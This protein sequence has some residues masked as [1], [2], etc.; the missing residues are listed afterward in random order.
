MRIALDVMGGDHAP[1]ATLDGAVEALDLLDPGDE[2]V[3]VGAEGV[4]RDHLVSVGVDDGRIRVV[5]SSDDITMD[6]LPV[7]AV[8]AKPDSSIVRLARLASHRDEAPVDVIISAGNTG[9]CVSAA[10]MHLRRLPH[11]HRPG[12]AVTI[13]TFAGPVVVC[14]VGAN[15]QPRPT[16]LW[17]YGL[18]AESYARQVHG[19]EHPR[20]AVLNIGGE[21]AKGTGLIRETRNLF[22]STPGVDYVGYI[23]GRSLFE[24]EADVVV[25]DGFVGNVVLKLSEGLAKGLF[26]TILA[27]L[28][29]IDPDM[30]QAFAPIIRTIWSRHDY[31]ELGGAPLLGVNGT[32]VI[33]HGSS[34]ARTIRSAIRNSRSM[35]EHG[36]NRIIV[37]R[38]GELEALER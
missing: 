34:E 5:N 32:C 2:L 28:S 21:E 12:V 8:R 35:V 20:I 7:E 15:P 10:Q 36:L 22:R 26:Q 31:H 4:I 27:E 25:T 1:R 11:V 23:E 33:C 17:Q 14:D 29:S 24:G 6:D 13:P 9:A 16:H 3:L 38:L 30:Q 37:E 19:I 18:M